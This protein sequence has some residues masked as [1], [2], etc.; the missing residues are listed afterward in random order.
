MTFYSVLSFYVHYE[1]KTNDPVFPLI[2]HLIS[3]KQIHPQVKQN[4]SCMHGHIEF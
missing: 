2:K 3:A 1:T 4:K